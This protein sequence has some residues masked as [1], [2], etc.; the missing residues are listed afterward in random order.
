MYPI[1][2][3]RR[4]ARAHP[5]RIAVE[6]GAERLSYGALRQEAEALAVALQ[7]IDPQP[8]SRVGI[9]AY[10]HVDH[11]VAWLAVLAAGKTWVP[12]YPK[13]SARELAAQVAFTGASIVLADAAG[14]PLLQGVEAEL[15][16]LHASAPGGGGGDARALRRRYAGQRPEG[17]FPDLAAPQAIKFTGG[18][19]GAPKGVM[20]PFRAWNTN[21]V[22]QIHTY[23]L[24]GAT[25][26]LT[27]APIT[28]GTSTYVL[29]TLAAGG[30]LVLTDRPKPPQLL[31]LL[32]A[33]QITSV[34]VPPTVIY[35]L[36]A[37]LDGAPA[38]LPDL[39]QLV[40]GAGPM[41]PAEIA[42]ALD[43]FGPVLHSTYGQTEA[44]QIATHIGPVD[45]AAPGTRASVG[46]ATLLTSVEVMDGQ[47]RLLPPG[48]AGEVV[49]RGD[50]VMG[51]YWRQPEKTAET[52]V[53]GWL[54]TGDLGRL[55]ARGFLFLKGRL[56][57]VIITGGFNVYPGDVEPVL[58]EH[59]A[60]GD[61]AVFGAP[62]EKW[63]EAVQAA[64]QLRAGAAASAEEI[65]DFAKQRLGSV[66]TPKAIVFVD[67]LPRNAYG[68]LQ[69]QKLAAAA[70]RNGAKA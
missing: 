9:C 25:R 62:D 51:G 33:Q 44:P 17:V 14:L 26:Y 60:V 52:L 59:P 66:K 21:I 57:E 39:R 46:R 8:L 63:G 27:A 15:I 36:L 34:F 69:R 42:G 37:E 64:V 2:F 29:P 1:D 49:I 23:G 58:G 11:L 20:Q 13:N 45:L 55:D 65:L 38:D 68:K 43:A 70:A 10:N 3:F 6:E 61:V 50:L 12:L 30:T 48:E 18:T 5:E 40:Y 53:D 22:T 32:R 7:A 16:P 54:H 67:E 24:D 28:H 56:K 41:R 19:T 4:A 47:G 35:M 31:R